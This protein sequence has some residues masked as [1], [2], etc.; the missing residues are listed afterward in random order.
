MKHKNLITEEEKKEIKKEE[1]GGGEVTQ[2][3]TQDK[4]LKDKINDIEL[5]GIEKRKKEFLEIEKR[6]DEKT[7]QLREIISE[8]GFDGA[9]RHFVRDAA[10][11]AIRVNRAGH[12]YS[13]YKYDMQNR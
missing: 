9:K 1:S 11:R 10:G 12:R 2:S 5:A 4:T 6:V 8:T 13:L 7:K 3:L